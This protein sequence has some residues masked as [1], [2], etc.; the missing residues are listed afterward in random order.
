MNLLLFLVNEVA[1]F[2]AW[3]AFFDEVM[4]VCLYGWPEVTDVKD[5]GSHGVCAGM[6]AAYAFM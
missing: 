2:L 6:I 5:S 3:Y 4:A 1:M